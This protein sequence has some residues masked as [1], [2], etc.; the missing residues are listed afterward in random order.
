MEFIGMTGRF[1]YF[2]RKRSSTSVWCSLLVV[3]PSRE[4]ATLRAGLARTSSPNL[5]NI[6]I[7]ILA[8]NKCQAQSNLQPANSQEQTKQPRDYCIF[9]SSSSS[10]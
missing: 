7:Q 9:A 5:P 4:R 8:R 2:H 3:V 6:P 10:G 1:S